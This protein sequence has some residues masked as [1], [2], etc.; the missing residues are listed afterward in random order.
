MS[1]AAIQTK[2]ATVTRLARVPITVRIGPISRAGI[3]QVVYDVN[4]RSISVIVVNLAIAGTV[5]LQ[6]S[7]Q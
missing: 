7:K 1:A 6:V 3:G 4:D 5:A 2:P